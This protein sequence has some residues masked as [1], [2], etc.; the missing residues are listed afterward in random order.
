MFTVSFQ[1]CKKI[2]GSFLNATMALPRKTA[3]QTNFLETRKRTGELI[4][5]KFY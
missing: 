5:R 4:E 1:E 3:G 2:V